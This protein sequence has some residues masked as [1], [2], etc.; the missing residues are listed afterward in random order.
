MTGRLQDILPKSRGIC[1]S[2]DCRM[3][4]VSLQMI[5]TI[6]VSVDVSLKSGYN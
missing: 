5:L 6:V 1:G 3:I 2:P 4:G